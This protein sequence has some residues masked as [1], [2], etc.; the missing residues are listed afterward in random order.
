[1]KPTKSEHPQ[2]SH[3]A[4]FRIC[5]LAILISA[6]VIAIDFVLLV[7]AWPRLIYSD[8]A[9]VVLCVGA[10]IGRNVYS[11]TP[12]CMI[13]VV[14]LW[15]LILRVSSVLFP[16]LLIAKHGS[17]V[18]ADAAVLASLVV[19]VTIIAVVAF[20]SHDRATKMVNSIGASDS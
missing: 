20:Q 9:A 6:S 15:L 8:G 14:L 5:E 11:Y 3:S 12:R 2:V 17:I 18:T 1:M 16:N 7:L 4:W 13:A 19:L 10:C